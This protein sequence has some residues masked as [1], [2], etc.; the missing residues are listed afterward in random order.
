[1]NRLST[2]AVAA[3]LVA[4]PAL[5]EV[6]YNGSS[7]IGQNILPK[8]AKLFT[9][10][11]GIKFTGIKNDGS[12]K[13]IKA[14]LANECNLAG[15][16][17][18]PK[19]AEKAEGLRFYTIGF[20]AISVIV[21]K[22][23]GVQGLT[24]D[25][26]AGIFGGKIRNWKEVGGKDAPI[27]PITE[28]LGERRATQVVF[29][30]I[31]FGTDDLMKVYGDNRRELDRPVDMANEVA[32]S[33]NAI[34][35]VSDAFVTPAHRAL[36]IGGVAPTT[37]SV[38]NGSYPISRPLN[39]ATHSKADKEVLEFVKFMLTPEAQSVVG[40]NFVRAK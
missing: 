32:K 18:A 40:E 23:N 4:S 39:L 1:M 19:D 7:T 20:D 36:P 21:H 31:V 30:E 9:E 24:K 5:A 12:G 11:T 2:L 17:R 3:L 10:K 28:I 26:L 14:L 8:A 33:P 6:T 22:D 34:A 29:T 15:I 37:E 38:I 16:S 27:V 25:Q 35:P 13:G